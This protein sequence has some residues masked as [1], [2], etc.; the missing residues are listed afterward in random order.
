LVQNQSWAWI[1]PIWFASS[2]VGAILSTVAGRREARQNRRVTFLDRAIGATWTG[3]TITL[4]LLMV[5][6]AFGGPPLVMAIPFVAGTGHFVMAGLLQQRIWLLAAGL[7]W[8]AGIW[9]V[10]QPELTFAILSLI[11]SIGYVVPGVAGWW[12]SRGESK[13]ADA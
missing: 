1:W 8:L 2:A 13:G 6:S 7:W 9:I 12:R 3:V 10:V 5:V 4:L 11:V